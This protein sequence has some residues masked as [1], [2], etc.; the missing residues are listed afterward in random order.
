ME[1]IIAELRVAGLSASV[2]LAF[3][4][5]GIEQET[6]MRWADEAVYAAKAA[7]KNG[8]RFASDS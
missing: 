2:G 8:Y 1:R 4:P 3:T 6:L 7:G 5:L